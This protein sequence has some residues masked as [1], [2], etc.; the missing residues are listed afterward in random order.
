MLY[1]VFVLKIVSLL[2]GKIY[3]HIYKSKTAIE[4]MKFSMKHELNC[5]TRNKILLV[6]CQNYKTL[7]MNHC[8]SYVVK[9]KKNMFHIA[10]IFDNNLFSCIFVYLNYTLYKTAFSASYVWKYL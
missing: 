4:T 9:I 7:I 5:S 8:S 1:N 2:K 3:F 10:K 6:F